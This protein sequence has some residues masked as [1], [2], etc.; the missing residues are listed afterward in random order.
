[1]FWISNYDGTA[2]QYQEKLIAKGDDFAIYHN[3]SEWND[4]E[5][6]DYFALFDGIYYQTCDLDM[7]TDE[8]RA[9]LTALRPFEPGAQVEITS[10]DDARVTV[11][12]AK[13]F[14]LMGRNWPAHEMSLSYKNED[15]DSEETITVLDDLPLTVAIKWDEN[16]QD[17]AM[18][19]TRAK[20]ELTPEI[21]QD[22]IGNCAS[23]LKDPE[24]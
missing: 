22:L 7:P 21:N 11:G 12:E 16:S 13:D 10:G 1:M 24:E 20:A 2:D 19:V 18:L 4:G 5:P 23:L 15:G 3:I 6:S 14:F 9:A 8:E 17:T